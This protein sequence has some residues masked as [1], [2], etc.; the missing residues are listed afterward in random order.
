MRATFDIAAR[1]MAFADGR[2][3]IGT[4]SECLAHGFFPNLRQQRRRRL[5][6]LAVFQLCNPVRGR[7]TRALHSTRGTRCNCRSRTTR[8]HRSVAS[9]SY[10]RRRFVPVAKTSATMPPYPFHRLL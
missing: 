8:R 5:V 10:A 3:A 4:G 7:H 2:A 1:V 6:Q 9:T